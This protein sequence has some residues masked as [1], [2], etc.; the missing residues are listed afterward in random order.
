MSQYA[1]KMN[2]DTSNIVE[3][4]VSEIA[5]P[6]SKVSQNI[7]NW[8][9]FFIAFPAIELFGNSI[10]FYLFIAIG[11]RIGAFWE[12]AFK[13]KVLL[14]LFLILAISSTILAPYMPRHEGFVASVKILIQYAYWIFVALFFISQQKRIDFLQLSK[15]IFWGTIIASGCFYFL[16]VSFG[17]VIFG[18][19]LGSSRNA[20]V[21]NL[22]STIPIS[23][24]YIVNKWGKKRAIW[25]MPV[26][27]LIM[28]LT[29]GRSGAVLIIL[30]M[31]IILTIIYP[32]VQKAARV[33]LPIFGLLYIVMQSDLSQI[34]MDALATEVESFNPRFASLLRGEGEGD[35]TYDKSWLVRKLMVDKGLEIFNEYPISG[36][37]PNNFDQ[38]DS[39]LSTI[40]QYDRLSGQNTEFYNSRSAHNSYIQLL[41]EMGVPGFLVLIALLITPI[42]FFARIFFSNKMGIEYL[43]LVSLVGISIHLYAIAAL[44]GAIAWM[45]IGISWGILNNSN[46]LR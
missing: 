5:R 17:N 40:N 21:F 7:L 20:F 32:A 29:G 23:F 22:L 26:F 27:L 37:G 2:E 45:V 15:W 33:L 44:T 4:R 14:L 31:I 19:N 3:Q 42:L 39:K 43:P 24:Y 30:Q 41:A 18:I 13:G 9:V 34:Y 10:T 38:Y 46:R 11:V 1:V 36:I 12:G 16:N 35:L 8:F 25:S 6:F 28:L